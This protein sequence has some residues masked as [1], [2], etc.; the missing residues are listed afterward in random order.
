MRL[1]ACQHDIA[2]ADPAATQAHVAALLDHADVQN[3]DLIALPE[4][5]AT[6]YTKDLATLHDQDG[7]TQRFLAGLA[8]QYQ[9]YL[10]AGVVRLT[11]DGRG[12]NLCLIF[13]PQGETIA[14]YQKIHPF[15][16]SGENELF[17]PGG[18]VI[19]FPWRGATVCPLV[20]YDLR[21]PEAFRQGAAAGAEIFI[22][23]ASWPTQRVEHWLALLTARA[24]ENQAYVL[25]V[26]RCGADPRNHYPGRSRI[27][28][29]QGRILSDAGDGDHVIAAPVDLEA[30]Q[31]YRAAFP[32][33]QDRRL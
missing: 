20:C 33:L 9:V 29:P 31:E 1:L 16:F 18:E 26:N 4:M 19:T 17:Q 5:F 32:A 3:G 25:A 22:V 12:R 21:F 30:L 14:S 2:Y 7:R 10:A 23:I 15:T 11:D 13:N 8:N 27:I 24:I 6:G 28:D